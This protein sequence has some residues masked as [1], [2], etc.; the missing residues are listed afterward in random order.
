MATDYH[1]VDDTTNRFGNFKEVMI[2]AIPG[3]LR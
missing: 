3:P 1:V 2:K